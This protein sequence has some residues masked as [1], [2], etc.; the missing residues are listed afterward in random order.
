MSESWFKK[1]HPITGKK[2]VS[3]ND[4]RAFIRR[5]KTEKVVIPTK[6]KEDD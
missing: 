6:G 3:E 1:H 2:Y 4:E 5:K